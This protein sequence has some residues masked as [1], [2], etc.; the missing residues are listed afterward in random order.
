MVEVSRH[1]YDRARE[2]LS[3][4]P[5]T[6]E[7]MA[8]KAFTDGIRHGQLKGRLRKYIDGKA[9]D[10]CGVSDYLIYGDYLYIFSHSC[11]VDT[12]VTV[13]HVPSDLVRLI[14]RGDK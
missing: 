4:K 13:F 8:A 11:G 1:A 10:H 5:E 6:I 2:R 9:M 12:L 14:P 3:W 7:K